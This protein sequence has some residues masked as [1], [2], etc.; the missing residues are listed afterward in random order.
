[1]ENLEERKTRL[2]KERNRKHYPL[3]KKANQHEEVKTTEHE[4]NGKKLMDEPTDISILIGYMKALQQEKEMALKALIKDNPHDIS[5]NSI[6]AHRS[7]DISLKL[8]NSLIKYTPQKKISY[9]LC[10][11]WINNRKYE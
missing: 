6:L 2:R 9:K 10:C 11:R 1:M 3:K 4:A 5:R 7:V 8:K